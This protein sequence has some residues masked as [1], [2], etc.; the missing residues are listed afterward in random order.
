MTTQ[1]LETSAWPKETRR[2]V[3]SSA[4]TGAKRPV[5]RPHPAR[6]RHRRT[7]HRRGRGTRRRARRPSRQSTHSLTHSLTRWWPLVA[8]IHAPPTVGGPTEYPR[9]QNT[10]H[11]P[12]RIGWLN[13]AFRP[14]KPIN[15]RYQVHERR[16]IMRVARPSAT[17]SW[18]EYFDPPGPSTCPASRSPAERYRSRTRRSSDR[19]ADVPIAV[20]PAGR[21]ATR[22]P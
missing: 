7:T 13:A 11:A 21:R 12:N 15:P 18:R 6:L 17:S 3:L 14:S 22:M 16:P 19:A 4:L 2:R 10:A 9:R 1:I 5:A 8:V 20:R